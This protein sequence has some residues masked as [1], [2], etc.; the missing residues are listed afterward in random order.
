[1]YSSSGPNQTEN[2][3]ISIFSVWFGWIQKYRNR[4][5][6]MKLEV[7]G[8]IVALKVGTY[9]QIGRMI[10]NIYLNKKGI[11]WFYFLFLY[12]LGKYGLFQWS[13]WYWS[14]L[15]CLWSCNWSRNTKMYSEF[16]IVCFLSMLLWWV[17]NYFFI[18]KRF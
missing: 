6:L 5:F 10:K 9:I 7:L 1:M 14:K 17:F 18:L 8:L 11:K 3:K 12:F 2:T 4:T 16:G 15:T 13:F